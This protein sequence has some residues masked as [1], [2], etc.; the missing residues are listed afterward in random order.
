MA[1][2][3][4]VSAAAR[5]GTSIFFM[6]CSLVQFGLSCRPIPVASSHFCSLRCAEFAY[7]KARGSKHEPSFRSDKGLKFSDPGSAVCTQPR[8]KGFF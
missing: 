6:G 4:S 2:P 1:V 7:T 8:G 3:P 5:A